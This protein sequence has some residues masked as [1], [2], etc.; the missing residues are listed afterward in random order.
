MLNDFFPGLTLQLELPE[1]KI[2]E[3]FKSGRLKVGEADRPD[4]Q[5][6]SQLG[7]GAQRAIEMALICYLATA[8]D[9]EASCARKLLLIDEPELYLHPQGVRRVR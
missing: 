6:F 9:V 8:P 4:F 1:T 3:F 5:E 2:K 7:S